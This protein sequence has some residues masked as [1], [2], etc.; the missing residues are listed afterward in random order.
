MPRSKTT[1]AVAHHEAGHAVAAWHQHMK[2]R[3]VTIVP[4]KAEGNLGHLKHIRRKWFNPDFDTGTRTIVLA[5]SWIVVS[6][7]GQIAEGKF[8]C[9][10][11]RWGMD[12]DNQNAVDLAFHL[13]GSE[14]T[15]NAYLRYCWCITED[16]VNVRW[17][18]IQAVAAALLKNKTLSYADVIEV[19]MPGSRELRMSLVAKQ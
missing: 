13:C 18:T 3:R 10:R 7:A 5:Q 17:K 12:G 16:L 15:A 6:L 14:K 4:D 2:F 19:I 9:R 1:E 11:P 8:R